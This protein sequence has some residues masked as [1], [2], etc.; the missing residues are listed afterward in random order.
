MHTHAGARTHTHAR[1]H[2]QTLT[3]TYIDKFE[4]VIAQEGEDGEV[5]RYTEKLELIHDLHGERNPKFIDPGSPQHQ[6]KV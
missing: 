1:T 3:H 2:T 5:P 4:D 6:H